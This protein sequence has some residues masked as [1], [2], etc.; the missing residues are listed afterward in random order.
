MSSRNRKTNRE[1]RQLRQQI[2]RLRREQHD[3]NSS[4][5]ALLEHLPVHLLQKDLTGRFTFVSSSFCKLVGL[6]REQILGRTDYDLFS[7]ASATK[8][9]AD[10]QR[11]IHEGVEF[12]DIERTEIA[13]GEP[14][15][16]QVR[17]APLRDRTG[18]IVGVQVMFWD[19]T[20]EHVSRQQ[21]QRIESLAQAL[22]T[23]ALDAVLLVD[24]NGQVL[25]INP[26]AER[27]LGYSRDQVVGH[28]T[29]DS[30]LQ[31][32]ITENGGR[33]SEPEDSTQ[34]FVRKASIESIMQAATGTRIEAKAR[35]VDSNWFDAEISAHPLSIQGTRQGWALFIRDITNRKNRE[36]ELRRAKE[37]AEHA[38]AAKSEFVANVSHELRTPLTGIIGLHELLQLTDI[39]ARQQ[40]Y[41]E[42][43]QVSATNLLHLIDDLLDFSKIE[44]G[45]LQLELAPFNLLECVEEAACAMAGRAQLR[46][47]ELTVQCAV[48]LP[49]RVIGDAYRVR[50]ILLNLI[51]NAIKFTERGDICIRVRRAADD[52]NEVQMCSIR[53]EVHD[54]GIG[55]PIDQRSL[56]FEAFRQADT[57]MT[58]RYGGTGLGLAICSDLVNK[59]DGT[60]GVTDSQLQPGIDNQGS[61][62]YFEILLPVEEFCPPSKAPLSRQEI[63]LVAQPCLW[64]SVLEKNLQ[65][66]GYNITV[67]S[68]DQLRQR[69]PTKLFTAGNHTIVM[70]DV[71]ELSAWM[72]STPPVVVRWILI[73]PLAQAQQMTIPAWL[74]HADVVWLNRPIRQAELAQAISLTAPVP[75]APRPS[76]RSENRSADVLLVEDSPVN[77][78]VL[79]DML[80]QL[81]HRV[82]LASNGKQ[83]VSLCLQ[84]RFDLVLMD[85]QMP[86]LDGLQ[87]TKLIR[88]QEQHG[89]PLLIYA[90]TAHASSE[91]RQ[92]CQAVGM[93][94]FLE[95]PITME[96]LSNALRAAFEVGDAN[97]DS[98]DFMSTSQIVNNKRDTVPAL[99]TISVPKS[100][101][102]APNWSKLVNLMNNNETL[103]IDVLRLT[104]QEAP[105]LGRSFATALTQGNLKDA[106]RSIHTLKSNS[107]QLGLKLIADFTEQLEQLARDER[108]ELL[109]PQA[110]RVVE[111]AE[112]I[113]DW[114]ED[115]LSRH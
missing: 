9:V 26:A 39:N 60:I 1:I 53:F 61:C 42:L 33:V 36:T 105:R 3:A 23:A 16:M 70:L 81:G 76:V 24:E 87:A 75:T 4:Q 41:V 8:F 66:L 98:T 17:K 5:L 104:I 22:I 46:G 90:L 102:D 71:R 51:G 106:R 44:A 85:I 93:N 58:R 31:T 38:N 59:M 100:L 27:I 80:E 92:V 99:A 103:L 108:L 84:R 72:I 48:N 86:E 25:D 110:A 107:R 77:Q 114:A 111:L 40:N 7:V 89:R 91:D 74:S 56:I 43:A 54:N 83:A 64:R 95:K 62:F 6:S 47:L 73:T 65:Q 97:S 68:L 32:A 101:E 30:I 67:L 35:R 19:V 2:R 11:V 115:L 29:L 15:Y 96:L 55:V 78:I 45:K 82:T 37:A 69:Q 63:V 20:K 50:Q 13:T 52:T 12:D 94:G 18:Q 21:L 49:F 34:T 14:S 88:Q 10:D 109:Q 113:A 28:S 79:R 112:A 57:S